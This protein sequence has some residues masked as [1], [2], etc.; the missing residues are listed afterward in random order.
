MTSGT[1]EQ[2]RAEVEAWREGRYAALRRDLGWLTLA[3]LAWLRDGVNSA[4]S[5]PACDVVLPSGP[6]HAGTFELAGDRV[7]ARG[8]FEMA[9]MPIDAQELVTDA[10]G[11]ATLL[12][13]GSLRL[14]AIERG[15]RLAIRTWDLAAPA[16]TRFRGIDHFGVDRAWRL[17]SRFEATPERKIAVPDV[18]GTIDTQPSPGVVIIEIGGTEHRLEAL[19]GGDSGELWLVF[20]DATNRAETYGGG[21]FLY[22][23]PPGADGSVVVDFNRAYNPPCVFSPFATCPL[24]W[25]ANRIPVRIEA[26]EQATMITEPSPTDSR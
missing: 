10:G 22:T 9:G 26:G 25:A 5:D 18:L 1:D 11:D 2:H 3:G 4:G 17:A 23:P 20:G 14:C 21:R 12:E 24:P 16:R 7:V 15:G 6:G 13:L 8:A 19:E